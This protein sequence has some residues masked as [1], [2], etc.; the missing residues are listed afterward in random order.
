MGAR[1]AESVGLERELADLTTQAIKK[2]AEQRPRAWGNHYVT[3]WTLLL[4]LTLMTVAIG[5][6]RSYVATELT[7]PTEGWVAY[8][9]AY[10]VKASKERQLLLRRQLK[11]LH[12]CRKGEN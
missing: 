4:I 2:V 1:T 3:W 7:A 5:F 10:H 9:D 6:V 8:F 11:L 12:A